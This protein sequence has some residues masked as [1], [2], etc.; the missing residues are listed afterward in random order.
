MSYH[1]DEASSPTTSS[2]PSDAPYEYYGLTYKQW[3]DYKYPQGP[4]DIINAQLVATTGRLGPTRTDPLPFPPVLPPGSSNLPQNT[5]QDLSPP[6][7]PQI[8]NDSVIC[9]DID[10]PMV[11]R[12]SRLVATQLQARISGPSRSRSSTVATRPAEET[13]P[14]GTNLEENPDP[15]RA[16]LMARLTRE[17]RT[18]TLPLDVQHRKQLDVLRN[19]PLRRQLSL[20]K[21]Y[22]L[23]HR[24]R[25][26]Y[27]DATAGYLVG[28]VAPEPCSYCKA[29]N[30]RFSECIVVPPQSGIDEQPLGGVCVSCAYQSSPGKCS[31]Y[32]NHKR[33]NRE[34]TG[35]AKSEKRTRKG[36]D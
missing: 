12:N 34:R 27:W 30:G 23:F 9:D 2:T 22:D 1:R 6:P 33:R 17:A 18:A 26:D 5:P 31:F 3:C 29:G 7:Y 21:T 36:D 10:D 11:L 28:E 8:P 35:S 24:S 15:I 20:R 13:A 19:M 25:P 32:L 4:L 14:V 16:E